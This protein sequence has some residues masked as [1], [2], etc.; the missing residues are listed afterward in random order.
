MKSAMPRGS[1][2]APLHDLEPDAIGFALV[3]AAE[4]QHVAAGEDSRADLRG[5]RAAGIVAEHGAEQ[6]EK[7]IGDQLLGDLIG[8]VPLRDVRDLVGE[9]AGDLRLVGGRVQDARDE[10]RPVRPAARTH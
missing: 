3:V 8:G 9:H 7:T 2:P 6:T 10:S 1:H 5:A 4:L